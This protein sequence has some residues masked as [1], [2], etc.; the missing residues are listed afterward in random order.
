MAQVVGSSS[1]LSHPNRMFGGPSGPL[2][3]C[4]SA[5]SPKLVFYQPPDWAQCQ[6]GFESP[7]TD[8]F[9]NDHSNILFWTLL[10]LMDLI[11]ENCGEY[12]DLEYRDR[13]VMPGVRGNMSE[14]R[15]WAFVF[16]AAMIVAAFTSSPDPAKVSGPCSN[17][18]T[19]HNSQ[20]GERVTGPGWINRNALTSKDCLGCD[21]ATD[22]GTAFDP[23][24]NAPIVYNTGGAPTYGAGSMGL[25]GGNFSFVDM[26][27]TTGDTTS[28]RQTRTTPWHP[29]QPPAPIAP[30]PEA[31]T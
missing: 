20:D 23:V 17:C 15:N 28:S 29:H 27:A 14:G 16:I 12:F 21:S 25:A 30:P 6:T 24:T 3:L 19:M 1:L 4:R 8:L 13:I 10:L 2:F 31:A 22:P 11:Q 26:T 5:A 9:K 18:H 7:I